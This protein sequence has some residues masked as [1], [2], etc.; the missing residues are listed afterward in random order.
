MRLFITGGAGYVGSHCVRALLK[1]GHSVTVYDNLSFGHRAAVHADASFIRG[2]LSDAGRITEVLSAG[3]FDAVLHFAAWLNVGESVQEPLKYWRNNVAN[4]LTLLESM[5][6]AGVKRIVFSSTCA[7]FGEPTTVPI[8]EQLA[9][10]PINPYG[11]TKLAV[12]MMLR[13][14]CRAWGLGATAL[15]YFNASGASSDGS[16][17]ED[18]R[19]ENHLIPLVLQVALGQREHIKIFGTDYPTPDGS[20]IRDYIHVEDLAEAHRLALEAIEPGSFD[21]FNVGTGRGYSVLEVIQACRA[22]TTHPIPAVAVERRAGDPPALFA[23]STKLR[24]KLGWSPRYA[25]LE[26]IVATAWTWHH[27]HPRGFAE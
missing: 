16:I 20:C 12:E 4:S 24:S 6:A 1:A 23:D 3:R 26:P 7:I 5:Q 15:R 19:P 11:C 14:S 25:D 2:E 9:K 22:V 27:A 17:G 21:C 13:D 8:H 18:H 10:D